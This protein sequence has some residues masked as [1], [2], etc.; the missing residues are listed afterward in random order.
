MTSPRPEITPRCFLGGADLSGLG[1]PLR[2]STSSDGWLVERPEIAR[3]MPGDVY[4]NQWIWDRVARFTYEPSAPGPASP[5]S[6][7]EAGS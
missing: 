6:P 4:R 1:L 2:C 5:M 3:R 7:S